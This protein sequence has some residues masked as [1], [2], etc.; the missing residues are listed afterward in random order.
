MRRTFDIFE[1]QGY[2]Q[3]PG[4]QTEFNRQISD[5]LRAG[6]PLGEAA[7]TLASPN[8]WGARVMDAYREFKYG[9]NT[10]QWARVFTSPDVI[11]ELN[12]LRIYPSRSPVA[13]EKAAS[14]IAKSAPNLLLSTQPVDQR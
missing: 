2:R 14:I 8:K 11:A 1:A 9:K 4:S 13:F 5:R 12:K 3:A 6:G 10:E 7:A